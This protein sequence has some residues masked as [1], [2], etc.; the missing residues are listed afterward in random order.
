MSDA[1]TAI[2][3]TSAVCDAD[4]H[5]LTTGSEPPSLMERATLHVSRKGLAIPGSRFA[6]ESDRGTPGEPDAGEDPHVRFGDQGLG[7]VSTVTRC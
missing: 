3:L 5:I 7:A 1:D 2:L 4:D 6:S